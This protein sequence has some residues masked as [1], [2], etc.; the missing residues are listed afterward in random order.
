MWC[1]MWKA[2]DPDSGIQSEREIEEDNA[3]GS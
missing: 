1:L 2:K 3:F